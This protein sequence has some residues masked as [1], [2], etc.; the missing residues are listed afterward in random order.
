MTLKFFSMFFM[1]VCGVSPS[2]LSLLGALSPLGISLA[3]LASQRTSQMLGRVQ[4]SL[5][6]RLADVVL[7]VCM[8]R[9]PTSS[10]G[11][12]QVGG[13][14]CRL[15]MTAEYLFVWCVEGVRGVVA[16]AYG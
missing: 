4:I 2:T 14:L 8:A 7:L 16:A 12:V 1:Q 15:G 10:P 13:W 11:A 9:L 3:S 6:T 5:L